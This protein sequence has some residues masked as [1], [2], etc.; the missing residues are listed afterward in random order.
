MKDKNKTIYESLHRIYDKHR[1]KYKE[2]SDSKQ[3]FCMWSTYDPPDIIEGTEP[4]CDIEDAFGICI[5]DD[6]ALEL[7]NMDL[8]EAAK[9]INDHLN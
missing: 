4:F 3:M 8:D 1:R 5:D 9:R 2:N 6:D 7:Y